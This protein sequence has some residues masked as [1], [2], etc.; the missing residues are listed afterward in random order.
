MLWKKYIILIKNNTGVD[1]MIRRY[2]LG[3]VLVIIGGFLAEYPEFMHILSKKIHKEDKT[4]ISK[5]TAGIMRG[6]GVGL[7]AVGIIMLFS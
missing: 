4:E 1:K 6:V 7:I 5:K 3:F 2:I